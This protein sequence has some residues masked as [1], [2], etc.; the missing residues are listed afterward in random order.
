MKILRKFMTTLLTASLISIPTFAASTTT[1]PMDCA[2]HTKINAINEQNDTYVIGQYFADFNQDG[3]QDLLLNAF[4]SDKSQIHTMIFTYQNETVQLLSDTL[5]TPLSTQDHHST[6]FQIV[7]TKDGSQSLLKCITYLDDSLTSSF[8]VTFYQLNA[9]NELIPYLSK[10][11]NNKTSDPTQCY[12]NNTPIDIALYDSLLAPY[13]V[14]TELYYNDSSTLTI[15]PTLSTLTNQTQIALPENRSIL[16]KQRLPKTQSTASTTSITA[17]PTLTDAEIIQLISNA[18]EREYQVIK[19]LDDVHFIDNFGRLKSEFN[20]PE[21]LK[22]YLTEYGTENLYHTFIKKW[23]YALQL[24]DG[25]YYFII[26]DGMP[27]GFCEGIITHKEVTDTKQV[28]QIN[29][30]DWDNTATYEVILVYQE[31]SWKVDSYTYLYTDY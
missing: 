9:S 26:G 31:D 7:S 6:R 15:S 8:N 22:A 23:D 16:I 12:L 24:I 10:I 5:S 28:I 2:Y 18:Y 20:T 30:P 13:V 27:I 11:H 1:T 3:V 14:G 19:G 21:T 17:I 25:V 4:E 29:V